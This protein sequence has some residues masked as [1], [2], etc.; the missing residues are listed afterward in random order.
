MS[1]GVDLVQAVIALPFV[2]V[3]VVPAV[4]LAFTKFNIVNIFSLTFFVAVL[5]LAIGLFFALWTMKLFWHKG[6]GTP[7]PWAPPENLVIEGPYKYTRNP[8]ITSVFFMLIA[9]CLYFMSAGIFVWI[10]IFLI[11]NSI[12]LPLYEEKQLEKRFGEEYIKYKKAVPMWL[13][14][15][16]PYKK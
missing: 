15:L 1:K 16:T 13:P 14:K 11:I 7:A 12:Y 8:M 9:E 4:I 3:C 2:V 6:N 5:F 10:L